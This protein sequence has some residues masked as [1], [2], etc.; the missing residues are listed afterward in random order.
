MELLSMLNLGAMAFSFSL[1]DQLA[2]GGFYFLSWC[3]SYVTYHSTAFVA[4]Q[5][6][7][8]LIA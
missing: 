7:F 2:Q 4:C 1:R 8:V 5:V 6:I 3:A